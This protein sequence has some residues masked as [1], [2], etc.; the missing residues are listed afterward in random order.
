MW[1]W[2]K[3]LGSVSA[4]LQWDLEHIQFFLT[5]T[6]SGVCKSCI[7]S[8]VHCGQERWWSHHAA[9]GSWRKKCCS[10]GILQPGTQ[11]FH[12]A[13][14][15]QLERCYLCLNFLNSERNFSW[16]RL[17]L[18]PMGS[19]ALFVWSGTSHQGLAGLSLKGKDGGWGSFSPSQQ[20]QDF[21]PYIQFPKFAWSTFKIPWDK[22]ALP[23]LVP[24][25]CHLSDSDEHSQESWSPK[26]CQTFRGIKSRIRILRKKEH[27]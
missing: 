12:L 22:E 20:E 3:D 16:Q 2:I 25:S 24:L 15:T 23:S 11:N 10:R 6:G 5:L 26:L 14:M 21:L 1:I 8:F 7:G 17:S 19:G 27:D 18:P 9:R 4:D 13:A